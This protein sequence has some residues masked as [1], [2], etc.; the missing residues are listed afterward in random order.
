MPKLRYMGR[1]K[2][3]NPIWA[4]NNE[5]RPSHW[6]DE[7]TPTAVKVWRGYRDRE[8]KGGR[9]IFKPDAIKRIWELD[10]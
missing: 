6:E 1:D 9:T 8:D 10:K 4:E 3:G 5:R 2:D 7:D